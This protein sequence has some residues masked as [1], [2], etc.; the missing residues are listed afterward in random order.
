MITICAGFNTVS[1]GRVDLSRMRLHAATPFA[2]LAASGEPIL[3]VDFD[4]A[5][6]GRPSCVSSAGRRKTPTGLTERLVRLDSS[7]REP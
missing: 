5:V 2:R 1:F 3:F 6:M 7:E 4:L